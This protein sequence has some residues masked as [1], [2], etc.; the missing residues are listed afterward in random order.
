M[1]NDDT[2]ISSDDIRDGLRSIVGDAEDK[3]QESAKKLLPVAIGGGVL[4][5]LLAYIIGKRVGKTKSTV[6]EIRRI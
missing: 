5:L 2:P 1:A 4:L 6:V 3:A